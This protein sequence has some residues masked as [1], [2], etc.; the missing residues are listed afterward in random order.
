VRRPARLGGTHRCRQHRRS[1]WWWEP[2]CIWPASVGELGW[3]ELRKGGDRSWGGGAQGPTVVAGERVDAVR[4]GEKRGEWARSDTRGGRP[5]RQSCPEQPKP[6]P[7]VVLE[8]VKPRPVVCLGLPTGLGFLCFGVHTD[9]FGYRL[10]F[11]IASLE[12]SLYKWTT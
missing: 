6:A 7:N 9:K 2:P 1:I 3:P 10:S 8:W 11:W 5:D 12:M 4:E